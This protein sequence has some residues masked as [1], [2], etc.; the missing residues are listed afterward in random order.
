MK[1]ILTFLL[2]AVIGITAVN[3]QTD[4]SKRKP[5]NQTQQAAPAKPKKEKQ[6]KRQSGNSGRSQTTILQELANNMVF[7]QGGTFTMGATSE[8]WSDAEEREKPAQDVTL[9]SYYICKYE[10]TQELW[11]AFMGNNPSEF[12]GAKR[13]VENVSW[14]DC[15]IFIS[16]LNNFSGE[17]FRLPTEA[18]WEYAAR[19]GNKSQ[20]YKYSGSNDLNSVAWFGKNSGSTTHDVGTKQPNELGLYDMSGNVSEWCSDWLGGYIGSSQSNPTGPSSG[21]Y[22][23]KRGGCFDYTAASCRA[24]SRAYTSPGSYGHNNLGLRLALSE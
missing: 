17:H 4:E 14:D 9:S 18:E 2:I 15:K 7:V 6:T 1:R 19:G 8:Q 3:A 23:V 10:V 16:K 22:R 5:K 11:Q 13:P 12:K 20:G 21:I 24:S